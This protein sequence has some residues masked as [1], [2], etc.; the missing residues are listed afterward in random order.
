MLRVGA[1]GGVRPAGASHAATALLAVSAPL[2]RAPSADRVDAR[3]ADDP[4]REVGDV[5][6]PP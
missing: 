4:R 6:V 5:A 2:A 3:R 1:E